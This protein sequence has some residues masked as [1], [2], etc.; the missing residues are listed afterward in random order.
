[1]SGTR[2]QGTDEELGAAVEQAERSF[3]PAA[4]AR[5]VQRVRVAAVIDGVLA[6]AELEIEVPAGAAPAEI[7][8]EVQGAV[9]ERVGWRWSVAH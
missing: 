6:A 3:T 1:M 4:P 2:G 7:A 9:M 5:A 8:N